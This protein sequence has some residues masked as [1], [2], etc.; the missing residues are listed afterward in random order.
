MS[1]QPTNI[2]PI[3]SELIFGSLPTQDEYK[4]WMKGQRIE[5]YCFNSI[6]NPYDNILNI[7][8]I[9][10]YLDIGS[11]EMREIVESMNWLGFFVKKHEY[12]PKKIVEAD[13]LIIGSSTANMK[14]TK[15]LFGYLSLAIGLIPSHDILLYDFS[16]E[17]KL[18]VSELDETYKPLISNVFFGKHGTCLAHSKIYHHGDI[19]T[20]AGI[21]A[22]K[23]VS[24][25]EIIDSICGIKKD[26]SLDTKICEFE[27]RVRSD[28][29]YDLEAKLF[30]S[31]LDFIR[32]ARNFFVHDKN[33]IKFRKK[34]EEKLDEFDKLAKENNREYLRAPPPGNTY[35]DNRKIIK[36]MKKLILYTEIWIARYEKL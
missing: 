31:A 14:N 17:K 8:H 23:A 29:N 6:N 19:F 34:M 33:I 12:S 11:E 24:I 10:P 5:M 9:S 30:F 18:D 7:L 1:R 3:N 20:H 27:K 22:Y 13:M 25:E 4:A 32:A 26:M 16:I 28:N 2:N 36:Y 15:Q 35:V 21:F